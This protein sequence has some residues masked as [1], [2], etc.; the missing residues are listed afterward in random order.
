MDAA[1]ADFLDIEHTGESAKKIQEHLARYPDYLLDPCAYPIEPPN[2]ASRRR[3]FL[4]L[5]F[6]VIQTHPPP[7]H[8]T[9][10]PRSSTRITLLLTDES[11]LEVYASDFWQDT[12]SVMHLTT[13]ERPLAQRY[14]M[15]QDKR[16]PIR[17]EA[18]PSG[19][20]LY[21]RWIPSLRE[22]FSIGIIDSKKHL[23][24]YASWQDSDRVNAFW[25]ERGS[26]HAAYI[27]RQLQDAHVMPVIGSFNGAP[28]AYFELYWAK[29]DAISV[30]ANAGDYDTGFHALIGE[31]AFRGPHR[32]PIWIHSITHY[33]FLSDVRTQ[34]VMLEPRVDNHTFIRYL[35][36]CGYVIEKEFNFPHKRSAL[37]S[38][39]R[40]KFFEVQGVAT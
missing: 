38:M 23:Q 21:E 40:E 7:S 15:T 25:G 1:L 13:P 4:T 29:E 26:G 18:P 8:R 11:I 2:D 36:S 6:H 16:H 19:T 9:G 22:T 20:L 28:F 24:Q 10:K 33:L 34:R 5:L 17:P 39:T 27:Q 30:F 14:V 35:V 3:T 37:V 31:E 12:A 32:V